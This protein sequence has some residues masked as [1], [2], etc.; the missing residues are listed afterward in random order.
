MGPPV[1]LLSIEAIAARLPIWA[2]FAGAPNGGPTTE[3]L[4]LYN[5]AEK[6]LYVYIKSIFVMSFG[7]RLIDVDRILVICT[8]SCLALQWTRWV[9]MAHSKTN[10]LIDLATKQVR[11]WAHL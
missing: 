9:E 7:Y 6:V 11:D 5:C 10:V 4:V 2:E 8:C 3:L 1:M